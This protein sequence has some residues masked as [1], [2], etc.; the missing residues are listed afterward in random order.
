MG[1]SPQQNK[2]AKPQAASSGKDIIISPQSADLLREKLGIDPTESPEQ[3]IQQVSLITG[4][5]S[6]SPYSSAEMLQQYVAAGMPEVKDRALDAIDEE[7][8]HR[9]QIDNRHVDMQENAMKATISQQKSGQIGAW[10]VAAMGTGAAVLGGWLGI[11]T[12]ICVTIAIVTVGGPSAA[13]TLARVIDQI[14]KAPPD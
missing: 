14:K 12:G 7:R 11:P 10:V 1:K 5:I 13:T 3:L 2:A 6:R 9:M 8:R 4:S